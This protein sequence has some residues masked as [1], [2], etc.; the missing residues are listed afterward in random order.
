MEVINWLNANDGAIIGIAIA[1]L[2][3]ITICYTYLTWRLLK[4]NDT[5]EKHRELPRSRHSR[6]CPN[7]KNR[8]NRLANREG[9]G[10]VAKMR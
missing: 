10:L 5:P 1:I 8:T 4:A 7:R 6:K 2:V 3:I 9:L